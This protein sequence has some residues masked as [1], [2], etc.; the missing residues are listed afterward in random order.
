MQN[1]HVCVLSHLLCM[2]EHRFF[3][4]DGGGDD[5]SQDPLRQPAR[6]PRTR[7]LVLRVADTAVRLVLSF[8]LDVEYQRR[9]MDLVLRLLRSI[10]GNAFTGGIVASQFPT[11]LEYL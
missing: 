1:V 11:S 9:Q 8:F 3:F 7:L 2:C 10:G 4:I 5:L 6:R